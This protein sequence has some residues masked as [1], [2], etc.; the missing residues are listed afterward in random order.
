MSMEL[1]YRISA[2]CSRVVT[3]T[4]STSFSSA[5]QL[6]HKDIREGIFNIYGFVR[7]ADE[8]VDTFHDYDKN[9]LLQQFKTETFDSIQDG[10]SLNP[11]LQSFQQTVKKYNIDIQLIEDFFESMECDLSQTTHTS[12]SYEKYI[13]G[14]AEVIGLICLYVF[15]EGNQSQYFE[16]K[17]PARAL[18]AAFQKV[19]FL[20]DM[21]N[22]FQA[23]SRVY[24]PQC[25]FYNFTN[26]EKQSIEQDIEQDFKKAF[27]GI[28][29]LPSKARFGVYVAYKYY[30]SLFRKIRK[31]D[32]RL[33][34]KNR[35]RIP[36]YYKIYILCRAGIKNRLRLI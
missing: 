30:F 10:I 13:Y 1:F 35:I 25:D 26:L 4:Y 5:I 2:S 31:T 34:L 20:R 29:Q 27:E 8:I 12:S 19:N 11:I 33:L 32:S 9:K 21:N 17:E 16:L 22:D 24:F 3:K 6:L 36:D 14:S 28:F 15:C 18:G 23:L 7:L